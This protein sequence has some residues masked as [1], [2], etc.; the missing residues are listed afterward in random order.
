MRAE[1]S[2]CSRSTATKAMGRSGSRLRSGGLSGRRRSPMN[3]CDIIWPWV[4]GSINGRVTPSPGLGRLD[5]EPAVQ[6]QL[7][8]QAGFAIAA[9]ILE[10]GGAVDAV[11]VGQ[12]GADRPI[13]P[14]TDAHDDA[15]ARPGRLDDRVGNGALGPC[16]EPLGTPV[17]GIDRRR[18]CGLA[19][20]ERHR[21]NS[22][23][24]DGY[25]G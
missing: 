12:R 11:V 6:D 8:G 15:D 22:R 14:A 17:G 7:V 4:G 24:P 18:R 16:V 19:A 3:I 1:P 23:P 9:E 10:F 25:S 20:E 21:P 13:G 5:A 2:I